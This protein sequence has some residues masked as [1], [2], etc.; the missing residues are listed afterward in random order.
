M[1]AWRVTVETSPT[2]AY[3]H[4]Y[5]ARN[6]KV[7]FRNSVLQWPKVKLQKLQTSTTQGDA[8]ERVYRPLDKPKEIRLI[9]ILSADHSNP[10]AIQCILETHSRPSERPYAAPFVRLG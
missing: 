8:H 1:S 9:R 10:E 6:A 5:Y 7:A 2:S 4:F 3:S